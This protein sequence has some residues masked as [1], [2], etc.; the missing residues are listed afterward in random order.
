MW[1]EAALGEDEQG[2]VLFMFSRSPYTMYDFNQELISLGV[3]AAQHLEG[4]PEAQLYINLPNHTY[5]MFG[6]YETSFVEDDSNDRTW[7]IPNVIGI[8]M[9]E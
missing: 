4:G 9:K 5:E 1:S 3:V 7:S 8:R 2:N 6:S